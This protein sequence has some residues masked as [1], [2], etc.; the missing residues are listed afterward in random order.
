MLDPISNEQKIDF[1]FYHVSRNGECTNQAKSAWGMDTY[2]WHGITVG[3][4]DDGYTQCVIYGDRLDCDHTVG[5]DIR[6]SKGDEKALHMVYSG[7]TQLNIDRV[8]E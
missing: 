7:V 1:I 2:E 8:S 3:L 5:R 4:C 6:F